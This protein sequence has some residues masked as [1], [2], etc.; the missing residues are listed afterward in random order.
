MDRSLSAIAFS[1]KLIYRWLDVSTATRTRMLPRNAIPVTRRHR[2]KSIWPTE[3]S[4]PSI[5]R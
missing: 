3:I 2:P 4:E 1:E 5:A